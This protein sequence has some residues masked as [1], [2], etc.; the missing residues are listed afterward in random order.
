[1]SFHLVM[2]ST[3]DLPHG[4][5]QAYGVHILPVTIVLGQRTYR[6]GADLDVAALVRLVRAT[7]HYPRTSQP[8]LGDYLA[9]YR[10]VARPGETVLSI[11][12]SRHLSG[13]YDTAQA[14]A[15]ELAADGIRVVPF[16]SQGGSLGMGFLARAAAQARAQGQPLPAV[17]ARLR[18]LRERLW[19]ALTIGDLDFVRHSGRVHPLAAALASLLRIYPVLEVVHGRLQV[20]AKVRTPARALRTLVQR[21]VQQFGRRPLHLAVMHALAPE[22]AR[23]LAAQAQAA[24]H[25]REHIQSGTLSAALTAHLG[26]GAVGLVAYAAAPNQV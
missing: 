12:V 8:S 2:D 14:A 4:W 21:A 24:L 23:A 5:A 22:R 11:H 15:R 3:G 10:R 7:G 13:A 1:M 6:D 18:A 19:M 9:F 25:L 26:P 16:D 20:V 17:L